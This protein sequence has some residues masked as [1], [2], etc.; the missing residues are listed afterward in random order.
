MGIAAALLAGSAA[1]QDAELPPMLVTGTVERPAAASEMEVSRAEILARPIARTA[2]LLEAAPGL[3]VTQHSGEGKANQYFLRGFN[4]DHGTDLAITVDGMP[5]NMPTHGHGQGYAD[6][7]FLI[8]EL[9]NGMLVRKGPYYADVGD[10]GSAGAL[11]LGL[12]NALPTPFVQGTVGSFGYWRGLAA[13]S[14]AVGP[15]T[16][17]AAGEVASYDGPWQR[18]DNLRRLNGLLRYSHGTDL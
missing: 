10:F 6:L 14:M 9:V 12:V 8:P 18:P 2:E 17:L 15:G 4:L 3:I 5:V 11:G 1:A 7:N 16:L 13:G